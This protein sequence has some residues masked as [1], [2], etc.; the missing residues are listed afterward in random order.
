LQAEIGER[1]QAERALQESEKRLR[2]LSSQLLNAQ[3]GERRRIARELHDSIGQTLAAAKFILDRKLSQM[4]R[5][6]APAGIYLEDLHSMLRNGIEENRRIMTNLRPP[7]LDDLG[8]L[9]TL[10]WFC[11]EFQK[12]Y[13]HISIQKQI[14]IRE[15]EVPDHLKIVIFRVVQES[16][17]NMA[18]HSGGDSLNLALGKTER[19]MELMIRDNG[20]GFDPESTPKGLGRASMEERVRLSDGTFALESFQGKGTV[21]QATWAV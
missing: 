8:I 4:D 16:L 14:N 2:Y 20:K 18:K 7:L 5:G 13:P 17:N 21:V 1:R 3:E 10:N 19:T 12:V 6:K 9:T 11:R 15:D